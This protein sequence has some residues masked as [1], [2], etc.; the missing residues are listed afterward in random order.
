M[1]YIKKFEKVKN[2]NKNKILLIDMSGSFIDT[3]RHFNNFNNFYLSDIFTLILCD[4]SSVD[5]YKD[6]N[7]NILLK[8]LLSDIKYGS[9]D[10]MQDGIDYIVK[11]NLDG[12]VLIF[13]DGGTSIDISKLKNDVSFLSM[14]SKPKIV[15]GNCTIF[16]DNLESLD[17][18]YP[19][20]DEN[21][22]EWEFKNNIKNFNL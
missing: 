1:K 12:R 6:I 20:R 14:Y 13:S 22:K 3:I 2:K 5:L 4:S 15:G 8:L 18:F 16:Y 7:I 10:G 9:G 11:N 21:I 19:P 17:N